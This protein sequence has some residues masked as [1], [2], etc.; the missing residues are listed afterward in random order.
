MVP[1]VGHHSMYEQINEKNGYHPHIKHSFADHIH[2]SGFF[3]NIPPSG[4]HSPDTDLR[5]NY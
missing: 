2:V 1:A 3:K 4:G 5:R